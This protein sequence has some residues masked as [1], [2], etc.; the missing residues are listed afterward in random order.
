MAAVP[1]APV[2][3]EKIVYVEKPATPAAKKSRPTHLRAVAPSLPFFDE[4]P[5]ARDFPVL[6]S[7]PMMPV[8]EAV[9]ELATAFAG[10]DPQEM[11]LAAE[12][13]ERLEELLDELQGLKA[14]LRAARQR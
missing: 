14:R 4:Q 11:L 10:E 1:P 13:R 5:P 12:E 8:A 3:I 2:V 6:D 9:E 7:A